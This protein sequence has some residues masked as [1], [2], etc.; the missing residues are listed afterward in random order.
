MRKQVIT[1]LCFRLIGFLTVAVF[2]GC[3]IE[4][5]QPTLN[6]RTPYIPTKEQ[7]ESA[8]P[9]PYPS[10]YESIIKDYLQTRLKDPGSAQYRDFRKPFKF[11]KVAFSPEE[12]IYCWGVIV[13]IN[14]KNSY[15]GYIGEKLW[16]FCIR[17]GE[18][19]WSMD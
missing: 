18:V 9:G 15:G 4:S 11:A 19:I 1:I 8:D 5:P 13:W 3:A 7:V 2:A 14:A 17:D 12:T 6:I 16:T 10:N